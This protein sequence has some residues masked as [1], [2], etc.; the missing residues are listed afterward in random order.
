MNN[1]YNRLLII[2]IIF[3]SVPL[4]SSAGILTKFFG[5]GSYKDCIETGLK[6]AKTSREI[7]KTYDACK[8]DYPDEDITNGSSKKSNTLPLVPTPRVPL[9]LTPVVPVVP[10]PTQ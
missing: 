10:S 2:G 6:K 9:V 3:F 4:V 5:L 1:F 8:K 7:K